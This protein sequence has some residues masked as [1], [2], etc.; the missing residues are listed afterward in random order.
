MFREIKSTKTTKAKIWIWWIDKEEDEC[1]DYPE[2]K[3][4]DLWTN[5]SGDRI[6]VLKYM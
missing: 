6:Y 3:D 4:L 5:G 1:K 2:N